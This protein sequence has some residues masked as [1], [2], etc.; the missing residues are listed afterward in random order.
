MPRRVNHA[1]VKVEIY[2]KRAN[3]VRENLDLRKKLAD[4]DLTA[5]LTYEPL[6][7]AKEDEIARLMSIIRAK[8]E[9]LRDLTFLLQEFIHEDKAQPKT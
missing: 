5:A 3:L 1:Q 9:G 6:L 7:R 2:R 4:A 8:D